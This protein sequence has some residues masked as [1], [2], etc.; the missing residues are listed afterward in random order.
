MLK[1]IILAALWLPLLAFAQSYPSPTFQNLTVR[2]T[3]TEGAVA[4]TGG[5][6]SGISPPIPVAS[7][8]TNA[9]SASGTALD[10]ITGFASTG[11]LTR[12]GAGAYSFQSLTNGVTLGNLAQQAANTVLANATGSTANVT[13]FAMPSCSTSSSAL[14]WTSGTGFTCNTSVNAATLGGATFA[15]PGTIGGTTPGAATFTALT[16]NSSFTATNLVT[17]ADLAQQAAGTQPCNPTTS[18]G[19]IVA[20]QKDF[21]SPLDFGAIA[22]SSGA[23]AANTT[24]FQNAMA[25]NPVFYC[26]AG[27]TFYVNSVTVPTTTSR[28][29]GACTLIATGTLSAGVGVLEADT[30]S[31]GLVIDGPIITAAIAT[32]PTISGVRLSGSSNFSVRNVNVTA[33]GY[34]ISA[35]NS[36]NFTIEMNTIGS[37]GSRGIQV[38]GN[39]IYG[40]VSNNYVNGQDLAGSSHCISIGQGSNYTVT[41]NHV[42]NCVQFGISIAGVP[43]SQGPTQKFTVAN[44]V[45]SGTHIECV[46]VENA[47][48][49]SVTGNTCFFNAN[50]T[51]FGMSF[52]GAAGTSPQEV[53]N[54]ISVTGNTLYNPCKVGI[55]LADVTTRVNVVGNYI[56][57]PNQCNGG[58]ADYQSAIL[59]YGGS[60]SANSVA[61]NFV[62]DTVGHMAWQIGEGTYSD[63]TGSPN[64][65]FLQGMAGTVGTSGQISTVGSTTQVI[66]TT[67]AWISY[68]PTLT[69]GSGSPG[70]QTA[71]GLYKQMGKTVIVEINATLT[72]VGTC[73]GNLNVS[74]PFTSA[75]ISVLNG[76]ESAST[77]YALTGSISNG[78]ST[79]SIFK[80]DNTAITVAGYDYILNGSYE[81]Q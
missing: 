12:T 57:T 37:F 41:G 40:H 34:G 48:L 49:G 19:N 35:N 15:A 76:R 47:S 80:Y 9:A 53:T 72:T 56:Y 60:N 38:V 46:N 31:A 22:N 7:G 24:A 55:A 1:R 25:S 6:I 18:T 28:I 68:T 42:L 23:A 79:A 13:A 74:L 67:N 61:D 73:S 75:S 54:D 50:H 45:I 51:D 21:A 59:L 52:Y 66:N 36:T 33:A 30:N 64:G 39:S 3:T 44:N 10:N 16:A 14:N 26:P 4:I 17:N 62:V 71:T 43:S 69:C 11:F 78:S 20:C 58:T 65:N 81:R 63:G 2:G 27:Q 8:G 5:S 70:S 77:G 29:F 32:Y